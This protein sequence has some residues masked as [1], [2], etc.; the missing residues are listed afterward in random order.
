MRTN[1]TPQ[2]QAKT[3]PTHP[4]Q[5]LTDP[6]AAARQSATSRTVQKKAAKAGEAVQLEADSSLGTVDPSGGVD[7]PGLVGSSVQ[8]V[9]SGRAADQG[10]VLGV[11][12]K[13]VS[14]SGGSL[15][16]GSAIQQSFGNHDVSQVQAY[17]GGQAA[18]A[19]RDMGAMA[20]A[21]GSSVAFRDAAPDLHTAAHEAAHVVQQR[22]GV[23]LSGG[24]GQVGDRYEQH[25][26]AVADAVVQGRSA[27]ALLDPFAGGGTSTAVQGKAIQMVPV[28]PD[29]ASLSIAECRTKAQ[30]MYVGTGEYASRGILHHKCTAINDMKTDLYRGDPQSL[31]SKLLNAALV[32]G[33][34]AGAAALSVGTGGLAAA[35]IAG[36]AALITAVPSF[37]PSNDNAVDATDFCSSYETAT[38]EHWPRS[39]SDLHSQMTSETSARQVC[40]EVKALRDNPTRIKQTQKNEVL[41]EWM[42]AVNAKVNGTTKGG[43]GAED[44]NDA[45]TGRLHLGGAGIGA[46]YSWTDPRNAT[47][48]GVNLE[49]LRNYNLDRTVG[50]IRCARTMEIMTNWGMA[51]IAL[52]PQNASR[53]E[54]GYG[55]MSESRVKW[56]MA[57]Y[58]HGRELDANDMPF[59]SDHEQAIIDR[60]Y[61]QGVEKA[62]TQVRGKT[63]RQ[64]GITSIGN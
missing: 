29:I 43:M 57:S 53:M 39:V 54:W 16:H 41:D 58:F 1:A 51:G 34:A 9:A 17:K 24:V 56:V 61:S 37:M 47:M 46:T 26:D 60:D 42:N 20:Y 44:Y 59:E 45:T 33:I 28:P 55:G 3:T 8:R 12:A 30:E 14:G 49:K 18:D 10:N 35:L 2:V 7:G 31:T 22:G 23:Q 62:W 48:E 63:L 11:A 4:V 64:L 21:T 40:A 25:A 15:P 50:S 52:T 5:S 6:I 13:G 19:C 36:G 32:I 27:Q 38:R